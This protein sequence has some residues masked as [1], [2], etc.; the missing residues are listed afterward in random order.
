MTHA[1]LTLSIVVPAFNEEAN[2]AE[3]VGMIVEGLPVEVEDY[4]LI[5]VND[6]S[7]DSTGHI[8]DG[9]A[10]ENARIR[11]V[12]FQ[13]NRGKGA[14]LQAGFKLAKMEWIL[15]TDADLQID[16]GELREFLC[17]ADRYD[18]VVGYRTGRRDRRSRL[19][20]SRIY[21]GIIRAVLGIRLQ[22]INCPFKL[23]RNSALRNIK[24]HSRG[25]FVD[26]ELM[27]RSL[28]LRCR[29][30]ELPVACQ[31]RQKG[32]STVRFRHVLETLWEM[33]D[34]ARRKFDR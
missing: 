24:L 20:S 12:Q 25:F 8:I 1:G 6:G 22:D 7:N 33:K 4:E 3:A 29:I 26:T 27:Y 19:V 34:L 2:I 15:F 32:S 17:Y 30:K 31:P 9:L 16:I 18:L 23:I 14:A 5:L 11:V 21:S 13:D 10:N 28:E